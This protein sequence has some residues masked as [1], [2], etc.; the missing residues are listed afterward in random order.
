MGAAAGLLALP[1]GI[2]ND[3]TTPIARQRGYKRSAFAAG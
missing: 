2:R 3:P 1:T